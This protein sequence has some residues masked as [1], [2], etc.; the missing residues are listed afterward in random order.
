MFLPLC[1]DAWEKTT[2]R[3]RAELGLPC[4]EVACLL[5]EEGG[6]WAAP[7]QAEHPH[8]GAKDPSDLN[9]KGRAYPPQILGCGGTPSRRQAKCQD[10]TSRGWSRSDGRQSRGRSREKQVGWG[11]SGRQATPVEPSSSDP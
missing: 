8:P 9:Q 7:G 6:G 5:R 2:Q 3:Q 11:A 1:V 10:P 4:I